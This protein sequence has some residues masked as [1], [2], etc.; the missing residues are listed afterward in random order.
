MDAELF[1]PERWNE[2]MPLNHNSTNAKWGYLTFKGGPWIC[3]GMDFAMTEAA[4]TIVRLVQRFPV[5]K[6]PSNEVIEPTG[7]EKQTMTLVMS[8]TEGYKVELRC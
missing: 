7:V 8:I 6:L 5:I 1:R 4:Y 2:D 3:L